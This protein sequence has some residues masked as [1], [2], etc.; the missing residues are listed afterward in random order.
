MNKRAFTLAEVLITIG[1]IGVVAAMTIPV[2]VQ[3]YKKSVVET[4][5][6][7]FYSVINQAIKMSEIDNSE[8]EYW[9]ALT[10]RKSEEWYKKYLAKYLKPLKVE[11][12]E[13][14]NVNVVDIYF[15]DGSLLSISAYGWNFCPVAANWSKESKLA[16]REYFP[17]MFRVEEGAVMPY[18]YGGQE[19]E[20][21]EEFL[22]DSYFGC[23][24]DTSNPAHCTKLIQMNGWKIPKDYPFKF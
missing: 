15:A 17:F 13:L 11:Y 16:G 3:N 20:T 9:D 23:R 6:A 24:A 5:L 14:H 7:K 21:V 19:Y 1:I 10:L 2:L 22:N 18:E 4:R 12:N 8:T